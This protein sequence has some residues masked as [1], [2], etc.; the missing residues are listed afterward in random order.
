MAFVFFFLRLDHSSDLWLQ[1]QQHAS[2]EEEK[3]NKKQSH[4]GGAGGQWR[5]ITQNYT[6]RQFIIIIII[7]IIIIV[8]LL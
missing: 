2:E 4:K 7:I 8:G 6:I 3:W 1:R 5:W